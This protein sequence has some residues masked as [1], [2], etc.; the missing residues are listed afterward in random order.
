MADETLNHI[1]RLSPQAAVR[2]WWLVAVTRIAGYPVVITSTTRTHDEQR[3]L[4]KA[5]RS[6]TMDS[7]H[8]T[9]DAFDIDW[10][11]TNR[12]DV[13]R[14]FWFLVGPWAER[15]LG[16]VWGGRWRTIQDFGH[17]ELPPELRSRRA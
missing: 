9:G 6:R 8:L 13:P 7:A 15:E 10:F 5:G 4:V 2:A 11:R 14:Q 12:D 1:R 17:F 16:L 3:A